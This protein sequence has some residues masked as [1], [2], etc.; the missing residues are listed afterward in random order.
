MQKSI[1]KFTYAVKEENVCKKKDFVNDY[2][3]IRNFQ[4]SQFFTFFLVPL[5]GLLVKYPLFSL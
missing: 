5:S 4:L 2:Q 1:T 3:R